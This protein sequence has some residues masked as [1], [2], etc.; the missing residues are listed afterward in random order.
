MGG[1]IAFVKDQLRR[2]RGL[3]RLLL[4]DSFI[5]AYVDQ[6]NEEHAQ[7]QELILSG[8]LDGLRQWMKDHQSQTLNGLNVIALRA[9]AAQLKLPYYNSLSKRQL[10]FKIRKARRHGYRCDANRQVNE[11]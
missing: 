7:I 1:Q 8:D 9:I 5:D 11:I 10:V 4:S 2:W 3:E 6:T